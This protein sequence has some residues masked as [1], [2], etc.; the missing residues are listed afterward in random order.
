M[1]ETVLFRVARTHA[2]FFRACTHVFVTQSS[3]RAAVEARKRALAVPRTK[4]TSHSKVESR[5]MLRAPSSRSAEARTTDPSRSQ[6]EACP[7]TLLKFRYAVPSPGLCSG[8]FARAIRYTVLS[9]YTTCL[10]APLRPHLRHC[11]SLLPRRRRRLRP[12]IRLIR[13]TFDP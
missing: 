7:S 11:P 6:P 4:R 12:I 8:F 3:R 5:P 10:A 1:G 9:Y 13:R 2:S